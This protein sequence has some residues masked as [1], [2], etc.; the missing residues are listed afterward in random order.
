MKRRLHFHYRRTKQQIYLT[1]RPFKMTKLCV[2]I[3]AKNIKELKQQAKIALKKEADLIEIWLDQ[4][5][6]LDGLE[7]FI[8]KSEK[9]VVAVCKSKKEKGKFKGGSKEKCKILRLSADMGA[10]YVDI[11][12]DSPSRFIK[13]MPKSKTIISF[14]DFAGTPAYRKLEKIYQKAR[15]FNPLIVKI[16]TFIK[17]ADD[18]GKLLQILQKGINDKQKMIVIGMGNKGKL[19]RIAC[20]KMGGFMTFVSLTDKSKTAPG[21]FTI[22]EYKKV[23]SIL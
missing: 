13:K 6:S 11:S 18:A 5:N 14:H 22:E 23:D 20:A 8:Q 7:S 15:K 3:Q 2:P 10:S 19:A 1:D 17:N 9:P 16:A 12:L 4:L 21:Q